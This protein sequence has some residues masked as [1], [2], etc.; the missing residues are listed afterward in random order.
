MPSPILI[1]GASKRVGLYLAQQLHRDG[2]PVIIHHRSD[3]AELR[4]LRGLDGVTTVRGEVIAVQVPDQLV[5][6]LLENAGK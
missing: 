6:E 1:T 5:H 4:Q 3:S 2:Y